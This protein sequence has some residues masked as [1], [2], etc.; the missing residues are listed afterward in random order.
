[1][2]KDFRLSSKRLDK[3]KSMGDR[4]EFI[5][6]CA[7]SICGFLPGSDEAGRVEGCIRRSSKDIDDFLDDPR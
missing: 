4:T 5:A 1:M 6:D 7:A 2:V 3:S